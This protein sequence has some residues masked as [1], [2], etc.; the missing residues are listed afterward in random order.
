M[1]KIK[2]TQGQY[3]LVDDEDYEYLNQW[4]WYARWNIF[5]ESYY[6]GRSKFVSGKRKNIHMSRVIMDTLD[7][8]F[9]DHKDHN[10]LNNQKYNLRNVTRSENM[11]N[12]R[13]FKNNKL[14]EHGIFQRGKYFVVQIRSNKI[15]L[16]YKR[17]KNL[18]DAKIYR[19]SIVSNFHQEFAYKGES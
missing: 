4:K 18:D 5:T 19:D 14:G 17:F 2:L 3:A 16:A 8:E 1:K 6:A 13:T 9:C 7:N 11:K 10:T 12:R 15:R